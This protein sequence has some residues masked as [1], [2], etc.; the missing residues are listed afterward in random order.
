[1]AGGRR[2]AGGPGEALDERPGG[3]MAGEGADVA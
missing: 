1:M 3:G 2:R